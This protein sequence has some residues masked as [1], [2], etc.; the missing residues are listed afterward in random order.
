MTAIVGFAEALLARRAG[1]PVLRGILGT[2]EMFDLSELR[3]GFES[4]GIR[5]VPLTD[6]AEIQSQRGLDALG[7]SRR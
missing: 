6:V 2:E 1:D 3:D 4:R 5:I 7:R